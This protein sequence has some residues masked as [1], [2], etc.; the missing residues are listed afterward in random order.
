MR[1]GLGLPWWLSHRCVISVGHVMELQLPLNTSHSPSII[2]SRPQCSTQPSITLS[3]DSLLQKMARAI[4][5]LAV[6]LLVLAV[7]H[8]QNSGIFDRC[9]AHQGL[10][11]AHVPDCGAEAVPAT[12]R[13]I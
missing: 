9:W 4:Q 8:L 7:I 12:N 6:L 1:L 11:A 3:P 5:T 10:P 2:S 13:D